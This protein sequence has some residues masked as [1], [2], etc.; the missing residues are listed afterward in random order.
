MYLRKVYSRPT[1]GLVLD[2][3]P[4]FGGY[5]PTFSVPG[6]AAMVVEEIQLKI[7]FN[8]SPLFLP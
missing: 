2:I 5:R 3:E 4:E 6:T 1:G 8:F 7:Y